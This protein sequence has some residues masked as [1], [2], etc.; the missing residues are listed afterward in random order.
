V[1]E[2]QPAARERQPVAIVTGGA[3]AIGRAY[4]LGLAAAGFAVVVADLAPGGAVGEQVAAAGGIA[5][6]L[7][8]DVSDRASTLEMARRTVA[9]FGRIDVLVNN[10]AYFSTI[11][12]RPFEQI[13]VA[14]WD[15]AFAVNVRGSWLCACAVVPTMRAQGGGRIINTSSSAFRG[16]ATPGFA[17][18]ASSKAAIVGLTRSLARELGADNIAVNTISPDYVA[19]EGGLFE[20]QP[21]MEG[22]ISA[23]RSFA[24]PQTP[25]DLVGAVV[26][27]AGEGS[28][29]ITGQDIWVNG[30][31][32]FS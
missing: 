10:A 13:E 12:K 32:L 24:R 17:H 11:V 29:F 26:F 2:Q 1:G 18:Y 27:L 3:G 20:R 9:A 14:E 31:R 30:G 7:E 25:E 21:E 28:S 22:L 23:Q 5:L 19:H 16:G 15:L 4:C 6:A 8:V